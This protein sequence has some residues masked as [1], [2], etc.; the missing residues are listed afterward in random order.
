MQEGEYITDRLLPHFVRTACDSLGLTSQVFSDDWV[1]CIRSDAATRYVVGY[2][3]DINQAAASAVAIDKVAAYQ[4]LAANGVAAVEHRLFRS[5][6][7]PAL[8]YA[9]GI[10]VKPLAG[11]SGRGVRFFR[12]DRDAHEYM[13]AERD[14][15]WAVSPYVAIKRE[16]RSIVLDGEI[17]LMY[18]KIPQ[19][20]TDDFVLYNLS[21]GAA[22]QDISVQASHQLAELAVRAQQVLGLR[23]SAVDCIELADGRFKI[24]EVNDGIMME[25]YAR[26]SDQHHGRAQAVYSRIIAAM[27]AQ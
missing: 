6:A 1:M 24:L 20:N 22:P 7:M 25:W 14:E 23:V 12:T 26:M 15:A 16:V 17:L 21:R 8:R 19:S 27:M 11:T 13:L 5:G 18:E 9:E 4:V 10:V 2:K 3:F